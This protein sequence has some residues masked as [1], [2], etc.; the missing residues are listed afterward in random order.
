MQI[1]SEDF[2]FYVLAI[3]SV[4]ERGKAFANATILSGQV[5]KC[6]N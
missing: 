2:A 6:G 3:R 5:V 1:S 4:A